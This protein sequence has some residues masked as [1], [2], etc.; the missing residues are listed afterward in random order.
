MRSWYSLETLDKKA[1]G[2]RRE[3]VKSRDAEQRGGTCRGHGRKKYLN[4]GTFC[5]EEAT[6][7]PS[8]RD[9][10]QGCALLKRWNSGRRGKEPKK[11]AL[12]IKNLTVGR[13]D[14]RVLL[15]FK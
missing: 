6:D 15:H 11:T 1:G 7:F 3:I 8:N 2:S 12:E 5:I 4:W 10:Y 13:Q 14:A 9:Q